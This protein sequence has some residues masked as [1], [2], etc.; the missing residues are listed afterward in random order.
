MSLPLST[1]SLQLDLGLTEAAL[2]PIGPRSGPI[3]LSIALLQRLSICPSIQLGI[4]ALPDFARRR[5]S[6][7][8]EHLPTLLIFLLKYPSGPQPTISLTT[9][10][11]LTFLLFMLMVVLLTLL[12]KKLISLAPYSQLIPL[13]TIPQGAVLSKYLSFNLKTFLV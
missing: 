8:E 3:H 11:N 6:M 2:G 1:L 7:L 13:V 5:I 4:I 12:L 9:S 10:V